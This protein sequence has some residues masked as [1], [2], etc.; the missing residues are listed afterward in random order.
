MAQRSDP[1]P[2]TTDQRSLRAEAVL[3]WAVAHGRDLPWRHTR[4]PWAVLVSEVMAQQTQ[5]DRVIPKWLAF[6]E[7]WPTPH[8]CAAATLGDVLRFWEGLGYP[9]RAKHLHLAAKAITEEGWFPCTLASLL[10]LPGVGQYTARAVLAFAFEQDVAV[11]DT[12]T[13]RVLARWENR[14]LNRN[15]VQ[16]AADA[17]LPEGEGWAWN[18]AMLDLGALVCTRTNPKCIDCPVIRMC[19]YGMAAGAAE[20]VSDPA[21]GTAG[22]SARQATFAGSDRQYRGRILRAAANECALCDVAVIVGL[23][24]DTARATRLVESLVV[25]GLAAKSG[26]RLVLPGE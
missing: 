13:A 20:S 10:A 11:V 2:D 4:D 21:D 26:V 5:V 12:N 15:E 16:T 7:R 3:G 8:A 25:D 19:A 6:M 9:R 14:T 23:A 24:N 1:S 18:Q 17:A 22:V